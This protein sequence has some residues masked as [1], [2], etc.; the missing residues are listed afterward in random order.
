MATPE[1]LA[2][3]ITKSNQA[4]AETLANAFKGLKYQRA[5]TVKLSK[6]NGRPKKSGD[7]ILTEWLDDL[8]TYSRQ[9]GLSEDEKLSVA[10]DHLGGDAKE[11]VRCCP[12]TEKDQFSK[13]RA[14]LR[15]RF[16]TKE[17]VQSL[18]CTFYSRNQL[19][20]ESLEDYSRVLMRL[21]DR[22]EAASTDQSEK[23]ALGK[24]KESALK[25]QLTRGARDVLTKRELRRL[26][27]ENPE[28]PFYKFRELALNILRDVDG[29]P[30]RTCPPTCSVPDMNGAAPHVDAVTSSSKTARTGGDHELLTALIEGQKHLREAV[31]RL[32]QQQSETSKQIQKL[33][34]T[35]ACQSTADQ[36]NQK[37]IPKKRKTPVQCTYCKK[38]GHS[39]EKCFKQEYDLKASAEKEQTGS[40]AKA[41][42]KH[43]Q[44]NMSPPS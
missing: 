23:E 7:S 17:T 35:I 16:G 11:E 28:L 38:S 41:S 18:N 22:M 6:F 5:S 9:L 21:Y 10:I 43:V 31:E 24:L 34:N 42:D 27:H 20:G 4:L 14:L 13:L 37:Q 8:D 30:A 12:K 44:G 36:A 29:E 15:S 1:G 26:I 33:T 3:V 2:D 39:V 32:T 40:Q 25:E 19:E